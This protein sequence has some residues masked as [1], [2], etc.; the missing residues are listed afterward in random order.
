MI[1]LNEKYSYKTLAL[2]SIYIF[3][4][5]GIVV[6]TFLFIKS[7]NYNR[8]HMLKNGGGGSNGSTAGSSSCSSSAGGGPVA[9]LAANV[10][11]MYNSLEQS[12]KPFRSRAAIYFGSICP[13]TMRFVRASNQPSAGYT[14]M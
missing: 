2:F 3:C 1:D 13:T 8:Q 5:L 10:R 4:A 14:G 11:S 6:F 9:N 7:R 12:T